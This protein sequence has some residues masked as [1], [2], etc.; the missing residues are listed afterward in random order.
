MLFDISYVIIHFAKLYRNNNN[1]ALDNQNIKHL[2][3][4]NIFKFKK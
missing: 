4:N 3:Q 2:V 1:I